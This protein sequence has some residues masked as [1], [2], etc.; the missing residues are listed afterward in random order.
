LVISRAVARFNRIVTNN[1]TRPLARR[2]PSF[3]VVVHT[4]R[5]TGMTYRTPVNCWVGEGSA[6]IALTYGPH[7]DWLKN[8]VN[9]GGGVLEHQS[10]SYEVGMPALIGS[11]GLERMPKAVR[12]ILN[13]IRVDRFALL[14]LISPDPPI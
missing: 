11:E 12:P 13:V 14:P 10:R 6:I 1:L 7:T 9:A 4:G 8:L 5:V 3:A 2:L